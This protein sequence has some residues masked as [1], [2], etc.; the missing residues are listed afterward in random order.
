MQYGDEAVLTH[1]G[2]WIPAKPLEMIGIVDTSACWASW[3]PD[4]TQESTPDRFPDHLIISPF[5]PEIWQCLLHISLKLEDR[6]GTAHAAI[7][8]L[9]RADVEL[10]AH[11][12]TPTG[13]HHATLSMVG[14]VPELLCS[15][16]ARRW[17]QLRPDERRA[18]DRDVRIAATREI[19]EPVFRAMMRIADAVNTDNAKEQFLRRRFVA[20]P[21]VGEDRP[22]GLAFDPRYLSD[23]IQERSV[24]QM[25]HG[26]SIRW[27]QYPAFCWLFGDTRSP[28]HLTYERRD[29]CL[30][31]TE[32]ST[33]VYREKLARVTAKETLSRDDV[34]RAIVCVDAEAHYARLMPNRMRDG[35]P[36][37]IWADYNNAVSQSRLAEGA[38]SRSSRGLLSALTGSLLDSGANLWHTSSRI[39]EAGDGVERARMRFWVTR[40]HARTD[41]SDET[42]AESTKG[43]LADPKLTRHLEGVRIVDAN[44]E[45]VTAYTVFVSTKAG[46]W[47][48]QGNRVREAVVA[49]LKRLGI[50]HE[51]SMERDTP[52]KAE[53]AR[54]DALE[55]IRRCTGFIQILPKIGGRVPTGRL[56]WLAFELG[57]ALTLRRPRVILCDNSGDDLARWQ[58]T[59]RHIVDPDHLDSFDSTASDDELAKSLREGILHLANLVRERQAAGPALD[60]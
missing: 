23:D 35:Q 12:M 4:W 56:E 45:P 50:K 60:A 9:T 39:L 33:A 31:V 51:V 8:S 14:T 30:R 27:L 58:E 54:A 36:W 22:W 3:V 18:S 55:K 42:W 48:A 13:H 21:G 15:E 52:R 41:L 26:V 29:E 47:R 25:I 17:N 34:A 57:T 5:H 37:L 11:H 38:F 28:I 1:D 40:S 49:Q 2:I 53:H 59:Y 16:R 32:R 43:S 46:W 20:D 24:R 6:E 19:A 44:T 10:I 7:R